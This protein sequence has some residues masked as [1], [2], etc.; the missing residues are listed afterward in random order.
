MLTLNRT[1]KLNKHLI[2]LSAIPVML[3][4]VTQSHA[5]AV[6]DPSSEPVNVI[7]PYVLSNSDVSTGTAKAFRPWFENGTYSGDIIQ[8]SVSSGG[9]LSTD[10]NFSAI[11]PTTGGTNWSARIQFNAKASTYWDT[12][13]KVIFH[14]G[15]AQTAFRWDNLSAAQQTAYGDDSAVLEYIRGNQFY[16]DRNPKNYRVRSNLLG[17]IVHSTPVYVGAPDSPLA[18]PGYNDFRTQNIGDSPSGNKDRAGRIYVGANDGMVHAFDA[19]TGDEVFAY[20]PSMVLDGLSSLKN[21][22]ANYFVD[23]ELAEGDMDFT[24]DSDDS[25][26]NWRSLV[27]GGLGSGGKGFFALDVTGADLSLE[28]STSGNDNKILWEKDGSDNDMGHIHGQAQIAYL[29]NDQ[30]DTNTHRLWRVVTGNGYGSTNGKAVLLLYSSSGAVTKVATDNT[31]NNGLS[32]PVLIDVDG[33]FD[34]DY[35]YAGDLQGNIWKFDFTSSTVSAT[36]FFSG[37]ASKPITSVPEIRRH[38]FGGRMIYFGTGS[39]LSSTDAANTDTQSVYGIW[40]GAPDANTSILNQTLSTDEHNY[41]DTYEFKTVVRTSSNNVI[42]WSSGNH[43]GWQVDLNISGERFVTTPFMRANRLQFVSHNPVAGAEGG[44]AW[45]LEFNYLNGGTGEGVFYDLNRDG[46]L[47][48]SDESDNGSIPVGIYL[49]DGSFSRPQIARVSV[50][51]DTKYIN[52]LLLPLLESCTENCSD[53]F[54]LGHADVD[55]DSPSGVH[56][57]TNV[58]DQYCY[59]NG[60]R[61]AAIPV[62]SNG[63]PVPP[64]VNSPVTRT[65]TAGRD[66]GGVGDTDGHGGEVDGHQHEYDKAHGQVYIDFVNMEPLCSQERGSGTGRRGSTTNDTQKLE[67]I[68]EV[69]MG[70]TTRFLAVIANADL[71]PGST[72]T[73]G[74]K[75]WNSV[76]YQ[77]MVQR[78]FQAWKSPTGGNEASGQF[79]TYMVDDDGDSLLFTIDE[80]I[81]AGTMRHAFDDLAIVNG[82]LLPTVYNCV[83]GD[84]EENINN[85]SADKNTGRWRGG[86]LVTQLIDVDELK[87]DATLL[88]EQQPTD[89]Y[90]YRVV[91]GVQIDLKVDSDNDGT[92]ETIYGGLRARYRSASTGDVI[93]NAAFLYEVAMYWHYSGS[94]YGTANWNADVVGAANSNSTPALK[95][96]VASLEYDL[97]KIQVAR[98][99]AIAADPDADVSNFDAIIDQL[100]TK[101]ENTKNSYLETV[102]YTGTVTPPTDRNGNISPSLGPNF[103]TGRRTWIDLTP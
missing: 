102:E 49:G 63:D 60:D 20:I 61:A 17:H 39:L 45:L 94:C 6:L 67:R 32:P 23:G 18:L 56:D 7:P 12:G 35:G 69:N 95:D 19:A 26:Y 27:V 59:D 89:L 70:N 97:E 72:F 30:A 31:T 9:V 36:K 65:G 38:P 8:Y 85:R 71:S 50:S 52:G 100:N 84:A 11:P 48:S 22:V 58:A 68:T 42:N 66:L 64:S 4:A 82:G 101:I 96:A 46:N 77:T 73:L 33:D 103:H 13:R 88:I 81:A 41:T 16:E 2:A 25:T 93:T 53:G 91:N 92:Y 40:D 10:V 43:R 57:A 44:D 28:T 90:R 24:E 14:N 79:A 62:D 55:T 34:V 98:L 29:D 99:A 37:S 74:A 87:A 21:N 83:T 78:Q 80:L 5:A 15:S 1:S 54:Q 3:F 76:V 47:N 51:R 86:S 75:S